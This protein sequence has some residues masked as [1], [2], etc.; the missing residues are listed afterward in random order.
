MKRYTS[1]TWTGPES[2]LT[3][4]YPCHM[5]RGLEAL[6]SYV[7]RPRRPHPL[8]LGLCNHRTSGNVAATVID[9]LVVS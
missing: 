2:G 7:A 3:C 9:R 8:G 1:G 6:G 5:R 4:L